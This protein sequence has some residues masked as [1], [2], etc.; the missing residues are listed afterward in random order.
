MAPF[1]THHL[2]TVAAT[3]NG[4]ATLYLFSVGLTLAAIFVRLAIAPQEAGI[5]YVTFFPAV[6]MSA[7]IGGIGPGLLTTILGVLVAT[8]LF[9]PPFNDLKV[10]REA[11]WSGVV[12][13][14][15]GV[16][17]CSAIEAMHRYYRKYV[18][19]VAALTE[20]RDGEERARTAAEE[21]ARAEA[22]ARAAAEK[23]NLAKSRFLAAANHDLRQPYQALRLFH[24]VLQM[25]ARDPEMIE[26]IGQMDIALSGGEGLLKGLADISTLDVGLLAPRS[27]DVRIAALCEDIEAHH[28]P[29]AEAKGLRFHIKA[30]DGLLHVDPYLM[31]RILDNLVSNA[32]RF[33]TKGNIRVAF[34]LC[35][36]RPTFLVKDTGIGIAPEHQDSVFE[37][38]Y[39][40]GNSA[41]D[42]VHGVGLGL[43]VAKK[44][45]TLMGLD[46]RMKSRIG[47]GTLFMVSLP[48]LA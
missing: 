9:I 36:G 13:C 30:P 40:V 19:A 46:L 25:K 1:L 2:G 38:F 32:V 22:R 44:M 20:A 21:A 5:P 27:E 11:I 26:V 33:T 14:A 47:K 48:R 6:A 23:A 42:R 8:Y 43:A 15:D 39:Q 41:R 16:V 3:K 17:V 34:R 29:A 45:A 35:A 12:F 4:G 31:G 18:R 28:R 37:E 7:I 10:S 24:G